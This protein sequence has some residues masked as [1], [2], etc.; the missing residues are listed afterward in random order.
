MGDDVELIRSCRKGGQSMYGAFRTLAVLASLCILNTACMS[1]G[2]PVPADAAYSEAATMLQRPPSDRA[3]VYIFT[4]T[5][6]AGYPIRYTTRHSISAD[7]FIDAVKIGTVNPGEVMVFDAKPARYTMW[8]QAHNRDKLLLTEWRR[9]D[10]MLNGGQ[11]LFL[12]ADW[13]E[14]STDLNTL[15]G[16]QFVEQGRLNPK[17]NLKVTRPASC[18][19]TICIP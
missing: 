2:V 4:G 12:T 14:D 8:W 7:I 17:L 3:R 5:M 11:V 13:N 6:V 19:S 16:T 9:Q 15:V 1:R 18:P 10:R